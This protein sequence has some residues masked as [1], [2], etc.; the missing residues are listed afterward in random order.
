MRRR[1]ASRSR[2]S[3]S[4]PALALIAAQV[5]SPW[6]HA[7]AKALP[8]SRAL[9]PTLPPPPS[10]PPVASGSPPVSPAFGAQRLDAIPGPVATATPGAAKVLLPPGCPQ[11]R[12]PTTGPRPGSRNRGVELTFRQPL[13]A[14]L[15]FLVGPCDHGNPSVPQSIGHGFPRS[16]GPAKESVAAIVNVSLTQA[17][18]VPPRSLAPAVGSC[19]SRRVEARCCSAGRAGALTT[20]TSAGS[21]PLPAAPTGRH[22]EPRARGIPASVR[23]HG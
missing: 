19:R 17:R 21:A 9:P 2:L 13:T 3:G 7:S 15:R 11:E 20:R 5:R 10:S 8:S 6:P 16:H 22:G 4:P 1:R 14:M 23:R 18:S 12:L